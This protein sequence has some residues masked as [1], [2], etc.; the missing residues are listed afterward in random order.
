MTV[1][2]TWMDVA[3]RRKFPAPERLGDCRTGCGADDHAIVGHDERVDTLIEHLIERFADKGRF[4]D[5]NWFCHHIF[6]E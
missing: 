2:A 1:F 4:C 5:G 6:Y 3:S